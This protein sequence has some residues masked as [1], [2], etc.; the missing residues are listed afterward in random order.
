MQLTATVA[1]SQL[2]STQPNS[3]H[4]SYQTDHAA[5]QEEFLAGDGDLSGAGD[6]KEKAHKAKMAA[7][8]DER[9]RMAAERAS[10][11]I[12]PYREQLLAAVEEHQIVIIVAETG[13]PW[14][15]CACVLACMH[16]CHLN[17]PSRKSR[18]QLVFTIALSIYWLSRQKCSPLVARRVA[19][20]LTCLLCCT[21]R[22][23]Q[24]CVLVSTK[25]QDTYKLRYSHP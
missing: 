11:P 21:V 17:P 1:M 25:L 12:F 5:A 19:S 4:V 10:L 24:S 7:I 22:C 14:V 9:A 3:N 6:A 16:M 23:T 18:R 20:L 15:V 8:E 2:C 13:G